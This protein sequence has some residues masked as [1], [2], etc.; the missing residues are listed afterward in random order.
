MLVGCCTVVDVLQQGQ[1]WTWLNIQLWPGRYSAT[2]TAR[3]YTEIKLDKVKAQR[4]YLFVDNSELFRLNQNKTTVNIEQT[5]FSC[6]IE[7]VSSLIQQASSVLKFKIMRITPVN[8]TFFF[9]TMAWIS[10][11]PLR[12]RYMLCY[13]RIF[14]Y[15]Y[16]HLWNE[17]IMVILKSQSAF[18]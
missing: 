4:L 18:L 12:T 8:L 15:R 11:E 3:E 16:M 14:W 7:D 5:T 1:K 17:H 10:E 9:L 6:D 13:Q 2:L